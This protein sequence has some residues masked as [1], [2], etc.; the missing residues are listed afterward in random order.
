MII[1]PF[2]P[3]VALG[4]RFVD[5]QDLSPTERRVVAVALR[6]GLQQIEGGDR[7]E[8]VGLDPDG[9]YP[10]LAF[11]V[12]RGLDLV[13]GWWLGCNEQLAGSTPSDV[14]LRSTPHPGYTQG[15]FQGFFNATETVKIGKQILNKTL[16]VRDGGTVTIKEFTFTADTANSQLGPLPA[17]AFSEAGDTA[18]LVIDETVEG[19]RTRYTVTRVGGP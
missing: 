8:A 14:L 11:G 15:N 19:S 2:E 17:A 3:F 13:G 5:V 18:G 16:S 7:C 4:Y 6:D 10:I 9:D 1:E 12:F